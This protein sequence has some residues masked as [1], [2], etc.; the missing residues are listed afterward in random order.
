MRM[1]WCSPLLLLAAC[2]AGG[3]RDPSGNDTAEGPD[4][5]GG[6]TDT[7]APECDL[8]ADLDGSCAADDCD[9]DDADVFPGAD[10][11]CNDADDD[12]DGETDEGVLAVYYLDE[13][14]DGYGDPDPVEACEPPG[15]TADN[16]ADCNDADA[17][18]HP[19]AEE[20]A[21]GEDD[22]CDGEVDEGVVVGD[23]AVTLRWSAKGVVVGIENG[24]GGYDFGMAETGAGDLGWFGES[25]VLGE[26]P[27]G[28][29]DYGYDICH[30]L[31][32]TGGEVVH[33]SDIDDADDGSTL[34]T[35]TIAA[36]GNI[37]YVLFD[38]SGAQCWVWGDDPTYYAEFGCT[39]L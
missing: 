35:D 19:G 26:E 13:D 33:V 23:L 30:G 12:C 14:G 24:S 37:T 5:T 7:A 18:A 21:N 3:P 20:R 27:W 8:D 6:D 39:K 38:D 36:A 32:A 10:E 15:G 1:F 9:D 22:D 17:N 28:M 31:G 2:F 4:D 11:R 29:P 16:G 34:F 25:C